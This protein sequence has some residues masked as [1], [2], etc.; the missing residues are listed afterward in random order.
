M[1]DMASGYIG[2]RGPEAPMV[3][4][5]AAQMAHR[6]G[7]PKMAGILGVDA[8]EPGVNIPFGELASLMLTTMSG[9]DLCSGIGGL[10]LDSGCALEQMVID[11]VNWEEF[12]AYMR[13]F[14]VDETTAAL[15]VIR[16]V[17]PGGSFLSHPHTTKHFR[18]QLYFRNKKAAHYGATMSD[19]MRT[20]ARETVKR[21][22][23]ERTVEPLD[24]GIERKGEAVLRKYIGMPIPS[25]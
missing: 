7:L 12:R 19:Q 8:P 3:F 9:T 17:G 5:A 14:T 6:Y 24:S 16:E 10:G 18:S 25:V 11:A 2:Y 4:A 22:L 21:I 23:R 20:D 13:N 1:A 15:D